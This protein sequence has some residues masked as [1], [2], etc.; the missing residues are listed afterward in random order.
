MIKVS[1]EYRDRMHYLEIMQVIGVWEI[2]G[3]QKDLNQNFNENWG[4]CTRFHT[5]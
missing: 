4:L 2:D 1:E 3:I 5:T